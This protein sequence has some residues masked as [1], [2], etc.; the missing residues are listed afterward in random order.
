M[1]VCITS[2]SLTIRLDISYLKCLHVLGA[3]T[4]IIRKFK[5]SVEKIDR[6]LQQ[7]GISNTA[8]PYFHFK[9]IDQRRS[10]RDNT[11]CIASLCTELLGIAKR[12]QGQGNSERMHRNGIVVALFGLLSVPVSC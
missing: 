1:C 3:Q 6:H 9:S 11:I 4:T 8:A 5:K 12:H 10:I 2:K 7:T